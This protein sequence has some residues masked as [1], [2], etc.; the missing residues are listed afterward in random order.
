MKPEN[1]LLDTACFFVV[2]LFGY[3]SLAVLFACFN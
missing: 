2:L 1:I 3:L